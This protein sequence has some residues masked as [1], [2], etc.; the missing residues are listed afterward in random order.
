LFRALWN[1]EKSFRMSKSGLQAQSVYRRTRD[2]IGSHLAI[3]GLRI[4]LHTL[5][6]GLN[7]DGVAS[8]VTRESDWIVSCRLAARNDALYATSK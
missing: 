6:H 2:S 7:A 8:L 3:D 4:V 1:I 5:R